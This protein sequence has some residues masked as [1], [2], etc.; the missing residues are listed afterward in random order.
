MLGF[1]L[2]LFWFSLSA[3]RRRSHAVHQLAGLLIARFKLE[4]GLGVA[5][6]IRVVRRKQASKQEIEENQV[7]VQYRFA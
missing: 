4:T 7:P 3:G 6:T 2:Q 1:L 5:A